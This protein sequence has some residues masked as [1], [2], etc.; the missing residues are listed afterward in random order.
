[1]I[2]VFGIAF[3]IM[4]L[5]PS[6]ASTLSF[7]IPAGPVGLVWGWFL[8]SGFIFIVGLA[9]ADLGSSM[10]TSGGTVVSFPSILSLS[11]DAQ[12]LYA[13][14]TSTCCHE[15]LRSSI[16][17]DYFKVMSLRLTLWSLGLYYW[18]HYYASPKWRNMLSFL[19]GYSN[20]LG[21]VGGLC[22]IDC[23]FFLRRT[24]SMPC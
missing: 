10:P 24:L 7:S 20:T 23:T 16:Y 6:I 2:E 14:Q 21:L 18:T 9:M 19:V 13:F 11:N 3:A 8:A 1:M 17:I 4:G 12:N 22:S 15:I 5:L